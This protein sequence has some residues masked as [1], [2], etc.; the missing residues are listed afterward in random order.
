MDPLLETDWVARWRDLVERRGAEVGEPGASEDPWGLRAARFAA[1]PASAPD[2]F[3]RV[4]D[5]WLGP[6][7]TLIDVGAWTGRHPVPLALRPDSVTA[8]EPALGTRDR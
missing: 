4:L 1:R 2:A 7:R 8:A 6:R 3:L 5:P